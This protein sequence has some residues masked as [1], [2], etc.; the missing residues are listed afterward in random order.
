MFMKIKRCVDIKNMTSERWESGDYLYLEKGY[1]TILWNEW[2]SMTK[3]WREKK[4]NGLDR[5][6]V[7]EMRSDLRDYFIRVVMFYFYVWL[8]ESI[9]SDNFKYTMIDSYIGDVQRGWVEGGESMKGVKVVGEDVRGGKWEVSLLDWL[10][11]DS[12]EKYS[13]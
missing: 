8:F 2:F 4:K 13:I 1:F 10:I 7:G 5:V 3:W 11:E 9:L 6:V 12:E